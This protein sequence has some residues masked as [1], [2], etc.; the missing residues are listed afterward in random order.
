MGF[1]MRQTPQCL[2]HGCWFVPGV[3]SLF[4]QGLRDLSYNGSP[5][6]VIDP[7][8]FEVALSEIRCMPCRT[9]CSNFNHSDVLSP[10][11]P[12]E[13]SMKCR[14]DGNKAQKSTLDVKP[15]CPFD[16]RNVKSHLTSH[17]IESSRMYN[18][19]HWQ[20][21]ATKSYTT[22]LPPP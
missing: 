13:L 3:K 8:I 21:P 12:Q 9:L 11:G 15:H 14:Y 19:A 6:F 7:I 16:K 18:A 2:P 22:T 10:L 4:S 5:G 1:P 17:E 20:L